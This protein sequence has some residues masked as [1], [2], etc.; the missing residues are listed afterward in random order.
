MSHGIGLLQPFLEPGIYHRSL[1]S[2]T[3]F[4]PQYLETETRWA[5]YCSDRQ[6]YRPRLTPSLFFALGS[7]EGRSRSSSMMASTETLAAR[8]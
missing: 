8:A 5:E 1:S 2:G 7:F 6:D 3:I 4:H